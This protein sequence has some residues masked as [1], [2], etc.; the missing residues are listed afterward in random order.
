MKNSIVLLWISI[1]SLNSLFAQAQQWNNFEEEYDMPIRI[2][3]SNQENIWKVGV[4]SKPG[5]FN[6]YSEP[7][8]LI[9]DL[10]QLYPPNNHSSF[11]FKI[12]MRTLWSGMP[13]FMVTWNHILDCSELVGGLIEVSYDS[14]KTW[15]NIFQDTV[16]EPMPIGGLTANTLF[17]GSPGLTG[18]KA[19]LSKVGF[20]W[21]GFNKP[22]LDE[23]FIRFSFLSDSTSNTYYPGWLIDDFEAFP[24]IIDNIEER[25][26]PRLEKLEI[27]A[28]PNP[29]NSTITIRSVPTRPLDW[30]S[31]FLYNSSGVL[32]KKMEG[33]KYDSIQIDLSKY[34]AGTYFIIATDEVGQAIISEKLVKTE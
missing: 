9:T 34:P 15:V 23:A 7:N 26:N 5:L 24:T 27:S 21:N 20:C 12:N 29:T 8:A 6:H 19:S 17:N 1:L 4:S 3:T 14:M 11:Y 10:H 16:Y 28:Y 22:P 33:Y 32:L 25:G 31:T 30:N 2:D 13:Y 18:F